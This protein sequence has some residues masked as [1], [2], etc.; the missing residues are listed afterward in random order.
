MKYILMMSGKKADW[1]AYVKWPKPDLQA[2]VAFMRSFAEELKDSGVFVASHF[3]ES[4]EQA[5]IVRAGSIGE[6]ITDGVFPEAKEFL[7]GFWIIDVESEDQAY[8]IAARASAAPGPGGITGS[9]PIE[10]RDPGHCTQGV[11]LMASSLE[12]ATAVSDTRNISPAAARLSQTASVAA[13]VSLA[14]L[15]ALSPEF[16]PA[17]RARERICVRSS[18]LGLVTHVRGVGTECLDL[19]L[20][21]TVAIKDNRRPSRLGF[22][23][24]LRHRLG[25][26]LGI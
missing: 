15:H 8:Q 17:R 13:L 5:K 9:M 3:L 4:P 16:D 10:V 26:G 6:P 18:C 14:A 11:A 1:D 25:H 22:S 19:G 23:C 21:H 2:H 20:C 24:C 7:A 12:K